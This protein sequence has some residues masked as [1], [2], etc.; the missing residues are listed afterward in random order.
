MC[1]QSLD[2]FLEF[3]INGKYY[4]VPCLTQAAL[5]DQ[6]VLG[7]VSYHVGG[8]LVQNWWLDTELNAGEGVND[9]GDVPG[10]PR[11]REWARST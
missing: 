7:H 2:N 10:F 6:W 8:W 9:G 5:T 11:L 1:F 3:K 4:L